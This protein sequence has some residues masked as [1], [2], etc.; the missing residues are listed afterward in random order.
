MNQV[1]RYQILEELGR[2]AMGVVYKALDPAIG[3]T[4][5]IKSIHLSNLSNLEE[6]Q[7]VRERLL[8]EAQ[9]AGLLSH[10]N[11]VTIYDVLEKEDYAY[12]FM[13][14][15]NGAS[16]ENMLRKRSLP[17]NPALLQFLRQV[18]DALDYAHRKG[19]VHCDIKPANIIISAAAPGAERLAK[20]ADFGVAKFVSHEM[21]HAGSMIGTPNYMS[22]EQIE[23]GPISGRSDQFSLG[24][25]VYELLTGE[26]PFIAESLPALF[27]LIC[28]D[29]PKPV[30]TVNT[31]LTEPVGKV[32]RR[33]LSK[34]P[35]Q[36]FASCGDFI[37]SLSIALA[38]SPE[39]LPVPRTTAV[40]AE[41]SLDVTAAGGVHQTGD[42]A[43]RNVGESGSKLHRAASAGPVLTRGP[44]VVKNGPPA[45]PPNGTA[46]DLPSVT[47]RRYEENEAA[48]SEPSPDR[49]SF[50]KRLGLILAMCFAIGAAIVFIVR[51]NSGSALPVQVADP[52]LGPSAP[53]PEI[54]QG[55]S[56]A[57][58]PP[59]PAATP[60]H[61][62]EPQPAGVS[63]LPI[64][65]RAD[66]SSQQG[67]SSGTS[68]LGPSNPKSAA[69]GT[70]DV[71]LLSEPSGAKVVVDN[72]PDE[73]CT[74]PCTLTLPNGRHTLT[75]EL[76][77][78]NIARRIFTVPDSE[79]VLIS[80]TKSM[81][82][83]LVTSVPNGCTVLVDGK[84]YGQT[85]ATLRLPAGPHRVAVTD[86]SRQHQETVEIETDAF[87]ARRFSCP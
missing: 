58:Q 10:P 8:R 56:T 74:A 44:A 7:R 66:Q 85:P 64:P 77:S 13:E 3:R 25:V 55:S 49:A 16:L 30:T 39:W 14:Y 24:V 47:R 71:E 86:G 34:D 22:P 28:K 31:S 57:T 73:S 53:P 68:S 61:G 17:D 43:G 19:I 54:G 11:I 38:D 75:A 69:T 67:S 42:A 46:Y 18:A 82:V 50:A 26:K 87:E 4:V 29:D 32:L 1:G 52:N 60:A 79:S 84:E 48:E 12:I 37:G 78:Y 9:S 33:A 27:Y 5:A 41:S 59:R 45:P 6:R 70:Q 15:V 35:T 72:R 23:G 2:G 21:T 65:N 36:R 40:A 83:L 63:R 51:W 62:S 80:M 76:G 81:G 20:I